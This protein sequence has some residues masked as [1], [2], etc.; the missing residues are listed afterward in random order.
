MS[1]IRLRYAGF[2]MFA[3]R[4][5]S[6]ATG[7]AFVLIITRSMSA[8]EFGV[9]GNIGDVLAYYTLLA[10]MVP[11]WTGRFVAR[12]LTGAAKTGLIT[13]LAISLVFFIL[14]VVLTPAITLAFGIRE[15]YTL[16][17]LISSFQVVEIYLLSA[18]EAVIHVKEPHKIGLGFTVYEVTKVAAAYVFVMLMDLK[19]LGAV[20][21]LLVALSAQLAFYLRAMA[22]NLGGKIE[23]S[24]V[25]EWIKASFIGVYGAIGERIAS[26][27]LILLFVYGTQLARAYYGATQA[28]AGIAGYS[29]MLAFGL[30][31]KL[32]MGGSKDDAST[33]MRMVAMLAVPM[34]AGAIALS[35]SYLTV[36]NP[37]YVE[38]KPVLV[39][40][41][42]VFFFGSFSSVLDNIVYG[43]EKVEEEAKI[44]LRALMKSGIFLLTTILYLYSLIALPTLFFILSALRPTPV[45]AALWLTLVDL[46]LGIVFLT[47][48]YRI[49]SRNLPFHI[50]WHA[51][52]KYC[53]ASVVMVAFLIVIPCPTRL[54]YAVAATLLG[55][56]V[57]FAVLYAIDEETR[58]LLGHIVKRRS[59]LMG[60]I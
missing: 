13:N 57:Y 32:L 2:A 51:M 21:A 24:Y 46:V 11:F 50:P 16:P 7:L 15:A 42:L 25:K 44:P 26:L 45:Y 31:P 54:S 8:E 17:Y 9:W 48:R 30:Y 12:G 55:A 23:R 10:S 38:A 39:V 5:L 35:D 14:Y 59:H 19:L 56:A 40:M 28:I 20:M 60:S 27:K 47:V 43:T 33:S 18:L 29:A 37:F 22:E 41:A 58:S 49:A 4:A 6:L 34:T 52:A 53:L 3:S 36:L 1:E